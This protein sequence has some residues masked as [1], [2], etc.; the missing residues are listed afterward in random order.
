LRYITNPFNDLTHSVGNLKIAGE[1]KSKKN[2]IGLFSTMKT[3]I[4]SAVILLTA[5]TQQGISCTWFKF[6]NDLG[7][8]FIG[9]SMEWPT[10]LLGEM[11]LVPRNF[12]L[13]SFQT[14]YG[15]V[16]I[17][18]GGLLFSDGLNEQGVAC[19][20]LWL[21]ES[22]YSE[23][24]GGAFHVSELINYVLG[25]TKNVDEAV[26]F[27][28]ANTFYTSADFGSLAKGVTL[29]LH[30]SI[31]DATGRSVVVEFIDGK[32]VI[33]ENKVGAM[34]NDPR[35]EEQLKNW[36][37]YEGKK[38][39][40]DSFEAFDFSP[41]GKFCRMAALNLTQ[42]KVPNDFTAVNRAWSM[43]NTVDLPQGVLYWRHISDHPQFTSY[44]VVADLNNR[45][46]YF[47]TYDNY[48]IRKIDLSKIDFSTVKFQSASL[49]GGADYR[50]FQF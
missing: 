1:M 34:T 10:D 43:L 28:N 15:F 23:K 36:A 37:K 35:F 42:A 48:D 16:G 3:A 6:G 50:D 26:T 13:G 31:T 8:Y 21:D 25:N 47:R 41:E 2:Q 27:I 49:F 19:S 20:G 30:F 39:N 18:H 5:F 7:H 11:T 46:Y 44:A 4:L 12:E 40:E 24:T 45:V 33:N 38:F 17:S 22:R 32:A 29:L 14:K 9:R